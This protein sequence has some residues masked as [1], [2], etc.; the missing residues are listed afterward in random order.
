MVAIAG[1]PGQNQSTMPASGNR[2]PQQVRERAPE[3]RHPSSPPGVAAPA[4][5]MALP[6]IMAGLQRTVGNAGVARL[7]GRRMRPPA[8]GPAIARKIAWDAL[9]L[10]KSLS[11]KGKLD[12]SLLSKLLRA[13]TAYSAAS[14][15]LA[16]RQHL[17][18]MNAHA[19][20]WKAKHAASTKAGVIAKR[21]EMDRLE[22]KIAAEMPALTVA[23][24][25]WNMLAGL[26]LPRQYVVQI[27]RANALTE[28]NAVNTAM[29][30]GNMAAADAAFANLVRALGAPAPMLKQAFMR[31]HAGALMPALGPALTDPAFAA[32][33]ATGQ[34]GETFINQLGTN[35]VTQQCGDAAGADAAKAGVATA[36]LRAFETPLSDI[37]ASTRKM[38]LGQSPGGMVPAQGKKND[39][40]GPMPDPEAM[41]IVAYSSDM[42]GEFNKP[43][44]G[45]PTRPLGADQVAIT[46]LGISGLN[47]LPAYPGQVYRHTGLF[48]DYLAMNQVGATVA[49]PGF[50][51]SAVKQAACANAG[52][53]HDVLEII[54]SRTG[55]LIAGASLY[56]AGEAEVLFKPFTAFR[57]V[58]RHDRTADGKWS[59]EALK[60]IGNDASKS[61]LK[62]VIVKAEA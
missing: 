32:D 49:D 46:K 29:A 3:A 52:A 15:P 47:K 5:E 2:A 42:Y 11:I 28:A 43:L 10:Q 44:R 61:V 8:G 6:G 16:E 13:Y 41:A 45:D 1:R 56:G 26:G 23:V 9:P 62:H 55:R 57:V 24:A 48:A 40:L 20:A 54:T 7:V 39:T 17:T 25:G 33:A 18:E 50:F 14:D 59:R 4:Q 35:W 60:L 21:Q 22:A 19:A 12:N 27:Y 36:N 34:R 38:K 31:A 37:G 51:S 30:A 58:E 53:Q